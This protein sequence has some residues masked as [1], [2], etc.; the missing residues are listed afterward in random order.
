MTEF[1]DSRPRDGEGYVMKAQ[2]QLMKG[3]AMS[4]I[5]TLQ[6]AVG[7]NPMDY[8]VYGL[9]AQAFQMQ[10]DVTNYNLWVQAANIGSARTQMEFQVA[11]EAIMTIYQEITGKEL[12]TKKYGIQ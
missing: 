4:G 1:I 3:D 2:A 8:R 12:D 11:V 7:V 9:G 6:E 10:K 5:A